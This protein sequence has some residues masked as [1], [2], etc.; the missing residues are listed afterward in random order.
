MMTLVI[1]V[2]PRF[3]HS[4]NKIYF[5]SSSSFVFPAAAALSIAVHP[6]FSIT[7]FCLSGR[8]LPDLHRIVEQRVCRFH[9][10]FIFVFSIV[11]FQHAVQFHL[12]D[13]SF[14]PFQMNLSHPFSRN[15]QNHRKSQV[16]QFFQLPFVIQ[17]SFHNSHHF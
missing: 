2:P 17:D 11:C 13:G 3:F 14:V 6:N 12:Y 7:R 9:F 15:R 5:F 4:F 10:P 16:I 8:S 1:I